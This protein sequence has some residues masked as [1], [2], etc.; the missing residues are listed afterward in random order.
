[1][2]GLVFLFVCF[3]LFFL[4]DHIVHQDNAK[5]SFVFYF[6]QIYIC[7]YL[8]RTHVPAFDFITSRILWWSHTPP[9]EVMDM[10][11]K[12]SCTDLSDTNLA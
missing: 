12:F 10:A 2:V 8:K 1:V 6:T 9:F 7:I 5:D 11:G 3:V 4:S